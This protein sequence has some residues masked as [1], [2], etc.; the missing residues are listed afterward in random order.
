MKRGQLFRTPLSARQRLAYTREILEWVYAQDRSPQRLQLEFWEWYCGVSHDQR[1]KTGRAAL[2]GIVRDTAAWD[3]SVLQRGLRAQLE[4]AFA[5]FGEPRKK[6]ATAV[7]RTLGSWT[8]G[9]QSRYF[10]YGPSLPVPLTYD[11]I[12]EIAADEVLGDLSGLSVDVLGQCLE[13]K[14]YFIRVKGTRKIF[15]SPKCTWR[16]FT[17]RA[18]APARPRRRGGGRGVK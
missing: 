10:H 17:R 16:A 2:N 1:P 4:Q 3:W 12:A 8:A 11:H 18:T 5:R 13:C 9:D 15:C 7:L 6:P 14:H